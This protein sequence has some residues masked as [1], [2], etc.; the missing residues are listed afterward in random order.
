VEVH[1]IITLKNKDNKVLHVR[2]E[3]SEL[4]KHVQPHYRIPKK[5]TKDV[6]KSWYLHRRRLIRDPRPTGM[7]TNI[8]VIIGVTGMR[9]DKAEIYSDSLKVAEVKPAAISHV[10][11]V[12]F[13]GYQEK[14]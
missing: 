7:H 2:E 11:P 4:G 5:V 1:K 10:L 14:T 8:P 12:I 3:L 6:M 9:Q 13:N